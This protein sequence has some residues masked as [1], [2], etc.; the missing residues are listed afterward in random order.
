MG[1]GLMHELPDGTTNSST[2]VVV[3]A[4]GG[5]KPPRNSDERAM[6]FLVVSGQIEVQ[7]HSTQFQVGVLGQFMVPPNNSYAI[8]N[9]GTHPAQL[10][11]VQVKSPSVG[12]PAE[13][14]DDD[15]GDDSE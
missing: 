10:F 6:F 13:S 15:S 5:K 4:V 7:M 12:A 2:G 11:F 3:L 8:R 9:V 1:V 14:Q